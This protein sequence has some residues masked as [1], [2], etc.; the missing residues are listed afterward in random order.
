[1]AR[2]RIVCCIMLG[3]GLGCAQDKVSYYRTYFEDARL[4]ST[5]CREQADQ[6]NVAESDIPALVYAMVGS[7]REDGILLLLAQK[8][9]LPEAVRNELYAESLRR[10]SVPLVDAMALSLPPEERRKWAWSMLLFLRRDKCSSQF[11]AGIEM[12]GMYTDGPTGERGLPG[13]EMEGGEWPSMFYQELPIDVV[14]ETMGKEREY[15][16]GAGKVK[17]KQGK[18]RYGAKANDVV[19]AYTLLV[20]FFKA[21]FDVHYMPESHTIKAVM[22]GTRSLSG[23]ISPAPFFTIEKKGDVYSVLPGQTQK[24]RWYSLCGYAYPH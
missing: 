22:K 11:V 20:P 12:A 10:L 9:R 1:M 24:D 4:L 5:E 3:L 7:S 19:G 8:G 16:F 13:I 15:V 14:W 18:W 2:K 23:G 21:H 6:M 17:D